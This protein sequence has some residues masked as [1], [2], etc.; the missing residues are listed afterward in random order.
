[1]GD[2][3]PSAR[4]KLG[5][6]GGTRPKVSPKGNPASKR[7]NTPPKRRKSKR[8][9]AL[10]AGENDEPG[11]Q[12]DDDASWATPWAA[13]GGGQDAR[14][15]DDAQLSSARSSNDGLEAWSATPRGGFRH[16]HAATPPQSQSASA[17]ALAAVQEEEEA[18]KSDAAEAPKA[19]PAAAEAA[20]TAAAEADALGTALASGPLVSDGGAVIDEAA[21]REMEARLQTEV[22]GQMRQVGDQISAAM[23]KA[24]HDEI[25]NTAGNSAS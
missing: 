19:A 5:K 14:A 13:P 24:M 10:A 6:K 21:L 18:Q 2:A 11:A 12:A 7:A 15:A 8:A 20:A 3:A 17:K 25:A 4:A 9:G 22:E 23:R 1:M 16:L